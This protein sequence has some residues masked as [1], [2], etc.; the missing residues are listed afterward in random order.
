MATFVDRVTL[1]AAAGKGG[2]GCI[3]VHREKFVPLGGPDGGSGGRGGDVILV[4]DSDV[5]TLLDFHHSPHRSATSGRQ[6]HGALKNGA[7]GEDL[8]LGVPNGTVVLT[9]DGKVLADL[10]GVGTR[11]IAAKGG[12]GGLGNAALS[13]SRRRAP[14]FALLGEPGEKR[15]LVLEL[16]SVADIGLI[17]FPSAGK[18]SLIA[19]ISAARPKIA[20][21]PFTT[22][23][24][25]LGVVQAG[26][27]RFTVADVPGLIPGAS[28]GKGLG[29]EFLRHVERCAALVHVLDCGTLESNR[30]PI[31]DF[32]IIER[33]LKNYS[34]DL[35]D[36]PRIIALNK[37][38]LPDGQ[39]IADM[40][41][42][43]FKERGFEVYKIS[44][45]ARLGLQELLYAMARTVKSYR[46]SQILDEKTR[47]VLR[48]TPVDDRGFKVHANEDGS[49]TVI[50]AKPE[51]WVHQTN[52]SNA[53][54]IGYLADRLASLGVER[55]L[56]KLGA[57]AGD[58][59]R[60]GS[61]DD[62]VV[63]DW[64]PT[65]EAGAE[66]LSGPRGDDM[67]IPR[68]WEKFDEEAIDQLDDEELAQQ[69][70]YQVADPTSPKVE[71][72]GR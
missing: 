19:A 63:F 33:E 24:P 25:N 13:S 43:Q 41:E 42:P 28:E 47:I 53:E 72:E 14:G 48:P 68:G 58:E 49:F 35:S 38:D 23:A 57:K 15:T 44:A 17:G 46:S 12:Q 52:F 8:I 50:G 37:I 67:R 55:E 30:D 31:K 4:V 61:D 39:A 21:Y 65:I 5:T 3:S 60:I 64:E 54:A 20:D 70:E 66:L 27:S 10:I 26:D 69:W 32:E 34:A 1:H 59:V 40:V 36:R 45:A 11:F 51:R 2:D 16:K 6:G 22:L 56:F 71:G 18:S 9:K 7:D 62:A 29:L